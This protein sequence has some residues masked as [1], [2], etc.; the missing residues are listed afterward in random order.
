MKVKFEVD[1]EAQTCV[2]D[3]SEI[4]GAK[5]KNSWLR[6]ALNVADMARKLTGC[7]DPYKVLLINQEARHEA[8]V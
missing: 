2:A 8:Q 5:A 1:T 4:R 3:F 6:I 7:P